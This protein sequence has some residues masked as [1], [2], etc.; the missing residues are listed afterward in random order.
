MEGKEKGL[1]PRAMHDV[2][3][4]KN[5]HPDRIFLLRVSYMEIYNE[6]IND[7]L[8]REHAERKTGVNSSAVAKASWKNLR[9]VWS[10]LCGL[11]C[12]SLL[13]QTKLLKF[14]T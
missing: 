12:L 14:V 7:L 9:R 4:W 2:F 3:K 5:E 1:L 6:E 13:S 10:S 8:G 11:Q